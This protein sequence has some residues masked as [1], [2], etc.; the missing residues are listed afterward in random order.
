[1][2]F[3][4]FRAIKGDPDGEVQSEGLEAMSGTGRDEDEG[5][6]LP[7]SA[8]GPVKEKPVPARDEIDFIASMWLLGIVI[9][10]GIQF[11]HKRAVSKDRHGQIPWRRR[12]FGESFS[13]RDSVTF[14]SGVHR[15]R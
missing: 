10:R 2:A 6:G 3:A 15:L 4:T 5:T 13:K 11:D 9:H 12:A 14:S 1:M 7:R 8:V